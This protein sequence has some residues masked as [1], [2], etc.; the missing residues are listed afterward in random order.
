MVEKRLTW[1][2]GYTTFEASTG[3]IMQTT[4]QPELTA[5]SYRPEHIT[6]REIQILTLMA[7]GNMNKEIANHLNISAE[8][9]KKH[10]KNIY[11]KTG[12]HNKIEALNKTKWLTTSLHTTKTTC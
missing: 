5:F 8:T 1:V 2:I 4:Y 3:I 9:V 7:Q 6:P 12:A 10:L 11:Q